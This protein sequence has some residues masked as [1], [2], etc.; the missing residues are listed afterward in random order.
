M[1]LVMVGVCV[2]FLIIFNDCCLRDIDFQGPILLRAEGLFF[3][4]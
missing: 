3:S 4:V 2:L 1:A